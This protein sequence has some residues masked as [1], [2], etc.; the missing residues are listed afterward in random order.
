[1]LAEVENGDGNWIKAKCFL[2]TGSN[3]SLVRM[4]FATQSRLQGNGPCSV[5][6]GIAGGGVHYEQAEEFDIRNRLLQEEKSHLV[7]TTGIKKPFFNV[8]PILQNIFSEHKHLQ[9]V[10][11]KIYVGG[12]EVDLFIGLDYASLLSFFLK[13]LCL[14]KKILIVVL[15]L[16]LC[17]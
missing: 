7:K 12:G 9:E 6:F 17:V 15:Q 3:S 5:Q 11:D 13:R 8:K 4:K 1:M 10:R 16:P 14:Q 2:H